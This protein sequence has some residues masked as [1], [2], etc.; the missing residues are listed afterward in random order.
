MQAALVA[1]A[2]IYYGILHMWDLGAWAWASYTAVLACIV[3]VSVAKDGSDWLRWAAG[4][5]AG[6]GGRQASWVCWLAGR[7][8]GFGGDERRWARHWWLCVRRVSH[9]TAGWACPLPGTTHTC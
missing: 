3:A 8:A 9:C 2:N 6:F 4:R 7:P 5:P 1:I